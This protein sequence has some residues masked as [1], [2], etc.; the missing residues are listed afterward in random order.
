MTNMVSSVLKVM[1]KDLGTANAATQKLQSSLNKIKMTGMMAAGTGA[2]G[3]VGIATMKSWT[4]EATK[5]VTAVNSLKVMGVGD[6]VLKDADKFARGANVIG[7]S[8]T[9]MMTQVRN[10]TT[11]LGVKEYGLARQLAPMMAGLNFANKAL[12]PEKYD[13]SQAY[14]LERVIEMK[15]GWKTAADFRQQAEMMEKTFAGTGGMVRPSDYLAFIKTSGV[16][17]RLL[18]NKAFY[19][20][21]EPLIQEMGGSRVGTGLMSA[22]NNLA[23]GRSTVRAA[24]EMMRLGLLN[25]KDVEYDKV[26]QVRAIHPGALQN[27]GTFTSDPG[28][29]MMQTLVPALKKAGYTTQE[30]MMNEMGVIFGNR[31]ASGLFSIMLQQW[32][33]V[34]KN[35]ATSEGAMGIKEANAA[36]AKTPLGAAAALGTAWENLKTQMGLILIPQLVATMNGVASVLRSINS[37]GTDHP[38]VFKVITYGFEAMTVALI[39]M[40]AV[41]TAKTISGLYRLANGTKALGAAAQLSGMGKLASW[42]LIAVGVGEVMYAIIVTQ[43]QAKAANTAPAS[44]GRYDINQSLPVPSG[45]GAW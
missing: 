11:V 45:A 16:A 20:E 23:Q 25:P 36:A 4:D 38:W 21:M 39:E 40:S 5:Y 14:A 44:G 12:F 2:L 8:A 22:Y 24:R 19:Y 43:H 9:D 3:A 30:Q 15:G 33:K 26:G 10:L 35:M 1:I 6:A 31:T 29:W 18:N 27:F 42:N 7:A 17:G 28:Q 13:E 37:M 34:Q 32:D 41:L